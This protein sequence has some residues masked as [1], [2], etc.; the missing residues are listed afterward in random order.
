MPAAIL[1]KVVRNRSGMP[2][3]GFALYFQSKQLEGE[4]A[5][6]SWGVQKDATIEVKTR[7]R[8]GARFG[9][10]LGDSAPKVDGGSAKDDG[11]IEMAVLK[12]Y[13]EAVKAAAEKDPKHAEIMAKFNE[14][15]KVDAPPTDYAKG[16][17]SMTT[18]MNSIAVAKSKFAHGQ[19][20]TVKTEGLMSITSTICTEAPSIIALLTAAEVSTTA[21]YVLPALGAVLGL[22]S[23]ALAIYNVSAGNSGPSEQD[24]LVSRFTTVI[25]DYHHADVQ[26]K[27]EATETKSIRYFA[28]I[29]HSANNISATDLK[30]LFHEFVNPISATIAKLA[31]HV[32]N[33]AG[34][35]STTGVNAYSYILHSYP[36]FI[37]LRLGLFLL[38]IKPNFPATNLS[39]STPD[40]PSVYDL[41]LNGALAKMRDMVTLLTKR[42]DSSK[43]G[44]CS[45]FSCYAKASQAAIQQT[46]A[47]AKMCSEEGNDLAAELAKHKIFSLQSTG[48]KSYVGL[49]ADYSS[50]LSNASGATT[51]V[52]FSTTEGSALNVQ[53]DD[54]DDEV[55]IYCAETDKYMSM[56]SS[57]GSYLYNGAYMR[58]NHWYAKAVQWNLWTL[59]GFPQ[60][61]S[62]PHK[63]HL[64]ITG[65]Y[66]DHGPPEVEAPKDILVSRFTTVI[67]DYHHTDVQAKITPTY[68][69]T[70]VQAKGYIWS[71][72]G[73]RRSSL[74]MRNLPRGASN[75]CYLSISKKGPPGAEENVEFY[76]DGTR[77][78]STMASMKSYT[79]SNEWA[80]SFKNNTI[81]KA[82]NPTKA[83]DSIPAEAEE[84]PN[85]LTLTLLGP[86]SNPNPLTL[87]LA[88]TLT[89]SLS[90]S[91][92]LT[93]G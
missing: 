93:L 23:A 76:Y 75:A 56:K 27:I 80:F 22:V 82:P 90:L 10:D 43:L 57:S 86:L 69:H 89:L 62:T 73:P 61:P 39:A 38:R 2:P 58:R 26:A 41:A 91:L 40:M 35:D 3:E 81:A 19:P 21:S 66:L 67:Q 53:A 55:Y 78:A 24:I 12:K 70:D 13:R 37:R 48:T 4:A 28:E 9:G 83:R 29:Y 88:L 16:V 74:Q 84:G 79:F 17:K 51:F 25:Q 8:G 5:L 64:K 77:E 11:A 60:V 54:M 42:P 30:S 68:H 31:V 14:L 1:H 45:I 92:Y 49:S 34:V 72:S 32:N 7:G 36:L 50:P 33:S 65:R 59:F 6:S 18:I 15:T 44:A 52:A 71:T 63:F 20:D 47:Q 85:P 87:N 46:A